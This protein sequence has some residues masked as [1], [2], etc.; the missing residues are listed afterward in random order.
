VPF[1]ALAWY[2]N[3]SSVLSL[4]VGFNLLSG[5][6]RMVHWGHAGRANSK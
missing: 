3:G 1:F 6:L 2:W 5:G 4:I